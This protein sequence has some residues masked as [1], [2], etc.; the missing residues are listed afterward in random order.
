M[1]LQDKINS[2]FDRM[3]SLPPE[4]IHKQKPVIVPKGESVLNQAK[5]IQLRIMHS[6]RMVIMDFG[7]MVDHVGFVPNQAINVGNALIK[8]ARKI[9]KKSIVGDISRG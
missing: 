7:K 4:A 2:F 5:E 1:A 3:Q 9:R 6:D 8:E